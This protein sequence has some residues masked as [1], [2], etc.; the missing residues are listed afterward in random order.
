MPGSRDSNSPNCYAYAIGA[1]VNEQPAGRSGRIPTKWNDAN[2][3]GKSV[4]ADL[5]SSGK[6][7]RIIDG[8]DAKVYENEFTTL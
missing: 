8:P 7:V 1:S 3:V 2:D 6:I 4:E 5:R